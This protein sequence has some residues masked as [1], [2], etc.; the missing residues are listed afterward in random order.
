MAKP[1]TPEQIS[2]ILE[3]FFKVV[4]TRQYIGARYVPIFG[5]KGEESIEWD[6][7]APYEPL[8]IVLYQGNSYTSRQFVPVGVEI[9]NQEFWAITGNYNAQVELYRQEV[10]NL[11]PYD[12]TP[13]EDSTK[14]VTSDGIKKAIDTAVSVETTRAKEAEQANADAIQTETTRAKEAE[15][16]NADAIHTNADAIHTETNRAKEAEQEL[17]TF[18]NQIKKTGAHVFATVADMIEQNLQDGMTVIA[19]RYNTM[20]NEPIPFIISNS[21]QDN[22]IELNNGKYA[23]PIISKFVSPA[24]FGGYGDGTH[25]DSAAINAAFL[26]DCDIY[27]T[28][29]W[30]T[31]EPLTYTNNYNIL[32]LYLTALRQNFNTAVLTIN[33]TSYN[34]T[35]NVNINSNKNNIGLSTSCTFCNIVALSNNN[36]V[37][38]VQHNTGYGNHFWIS[39]TNSN[40]NASCTGLN[41]LGTDNIIDYIETHNI[42]HGVT[43]NNGH[44]EY[45]FVHPWIYANDDLYIN[46]VA[47]E[48]YASCTIKTLYVDTMQYGL[49]Y[50]GDVDVSIGDFKTYFNNDGVSDEIAAAHKPLI[51]NNST[52]FKADATHYVHVH[53]LY[54]YSYKGNKINTLEES[55]Y[56]AYMLQHFI[57]DNM[58]NIGYNGT[59]RNA[60]FATFSASK[61]TNF[62]DLITTNLTGWDNFVMVKKDF[63][64]TPWTNQQG[65]ANVEFTMLGT[66]GSPTKKAFVI[67]L[68]QLA[69]DTTITYKPTE[70]GLK[71]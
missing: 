64:P 70:I 16:A 33:T 25:D 10:R 15:Q 17:T 58:V 35:Y 8:T 39:A 1:F 18:V 48:C 6:N 47:F 52:A 29:M 3:E 60:P 66:P 42:K 40:I 46:S 44:N 26:T 27:S 45:I 21:N 41:M 38:A 4:G 24:Y 31:N 36:I 2:Q 71:S 34:K 5:R 11:L 54:G 63:S 30:Y 22:A 67:Y 56:N 9:T 37:A 28:H 62:T 12:E 13:T 7:S 53:N 61:I 20:W 55:D 49:R 14:A 57:I 51:A 23:C 69:W 68:K 32:S 50:N 43:N 65:F 19:L 59:I